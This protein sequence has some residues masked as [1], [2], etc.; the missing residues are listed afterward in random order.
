MDGG[1]VSMLPWAKLLNR[2]DFVIVAA[3]GDDGEAVETLRNQPID[4]VVLTSSVNN[5]SAQVNQMKNMKPN[6]P[7]ILFLPAHDNGSRA[8]DKVVRDPTTLVKTVA[9]L[10]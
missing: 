5:I 8:V 7:I 3:S 4:I 10:V 9:E 2:E 1:L 6:V